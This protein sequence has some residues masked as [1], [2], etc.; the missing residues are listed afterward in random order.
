MSPTLLSQERQVPTFWA[1]DESDDGGVYTDVMALVVAMVF[2]AVH[3][4]AWSYA[5]LSPMEQLMWRVSAV[6]I[7]AVPVVILLSLVVYGLIASSS[8]M[9]ADIVLATSLT[10]CVIFYIAARGV[11]L[12]LSFTALKSLPFGAYQTVQWTTFIQHV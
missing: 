11:L 10:V 3:C 2:G 9:L 1:S 7:V 6:S 5:F 12:V 4:I 8:E